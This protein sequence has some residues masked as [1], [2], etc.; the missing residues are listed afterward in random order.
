MLKIVG[1]KTENPAVESW[2]AFSSLVIKEKFYLFDE[3]TVAMIAENP[4]GQYLIGMENF[5][6]KRRLTPA[7]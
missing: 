7:R 4:H 2:M 1:K 5:W 3:D 6:T